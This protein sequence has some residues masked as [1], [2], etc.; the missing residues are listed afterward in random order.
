[1]KLWYLIYTYENFHY[2]NDIRMEGKYVDKNNATKN[3]MELTIYKST[4]NSLFNLTNYVIKT[5]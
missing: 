3:F 2:L 4:F 5:H 1:M